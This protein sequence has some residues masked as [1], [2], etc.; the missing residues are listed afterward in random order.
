MNGKH[1][2]LY[3]S[4]V[5]ALSAGTVVGGVVGV[6]AMSTAYTGGG[7]LDATSRTWEA[8]ASGGT[9]NLDGE[10]ITV[11]YNASNFGNRG[12]GAI[13]LFQHIRYGNSNGVNPVNVTLSG[14]DTSRSYNLVAYGAD[15]FLNRGSNYEVL[16]SGFGTKGT[17]GD[18]SASFIENTNYVRFD[19][20]TTLTGSLTLQATVGSEGIAMLNG[21][22]IETVGGAPPPGDSGKIVWVNNAG[23]IA[24]FSSL[25]DFASW[26]GSK[27]DLGTPAGGALGNDAGGFVDPATGDIVWV[28]NAGT[29]ITF[30]SLDDFV[31]L[32][33]FTDLGTPAGGALGNDAGGFVD[34]ATG[35][36]V[37]VNNAGT[38]ITFPSL[39]DL[40]GLSN[41]TDLGTPV[42]GA[43]GNDAGGFVDPATGDIVWV[44]NAGTLISFPSLADFA[45]WSNGTDRGTPVGGALG[46]DAGG[47]AFPMAMAGDIPEPATLALLGLAVTGLGGYVRRR[48][49]A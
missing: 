5:L 41:F 48:R 23:T 19:N 39:A 3:L 27:T 34:P 1:I 35:D 15:R 13:E 43:L 32:T 29:V 40:V 8:P 11:T 26:G 17:T 30:P 6:D 47:F 12:G 46:N 20:L 37:W 21:F 18:S 45:S 9:F 4:V 16:G 42:G 10:T 14:L 25:A 38:V 24:S 36:I 22:E 2:W 44:N 28:N 31:A 7:V 33:N 49:N